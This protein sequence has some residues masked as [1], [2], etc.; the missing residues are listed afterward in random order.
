[1]IKRGRPLLVV[2]A[3]GAFL[4]VAVSVVVVVS[5]I[6]DDVAS[7][8]CPAQLQADESKVRSDR[9]WTEMD[10]P[11][12]GDYAEV[13]WQLRAAGDPCLR[14]P[15]PT[16]WHYQGVIRLRPE[17]ATALA[18]GYSDWQSVP[19]SA[20]PSPGG[21][22]WDTPS[23]MWSAL[24]PFV[25]VGVS[26]SHSLSYANTQFQHGRW[27]DLYLDPDKTVAFFVLYDH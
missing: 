17:D 14:A 6:R 13:H 8:A 1:M 11:G 27:G 20:T 10:L 15:G 9:N 22:E 2:A 23:Q 3:V 12:V 7:R 24:V 5:L 19:V 4:I 21:Y 18:Q 26:W 25:P 16:D